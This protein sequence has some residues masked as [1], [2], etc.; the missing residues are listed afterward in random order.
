MVALISTAFCYSQGGNAIDNTGG[1]INNRGKIII[2][3]GQVKNLNDTIGGR[4]EFTDNG[5]GDTK[6]PNIVFN[7]LQLKGGNRKWTDTTNSNFKPLVTQDSIIIDKSTPFQLINANVNAHYH[8]ANNANIVGKKEFRANAT[9]NQDIVG[10][11]QFNILNIDN[12]NGVNIKDGSQRINSHLI[13]TNGSLNN[14]PLNN[15]IMSDS[16]LITRNIS[17]SI[18]NPPVFDNRVSV[19]YIGNGN[20]VS[21]YEIPLDST[22]LQNLYAENDTL[23]ISRNV[24]VNDSLHVTNVVSTFNP[25]NNDTTIILTHASREN[26]VY[27]QLYSEVIGNFRRT[28]LKF[29]REKNLFHNRYTYI[30][31]GR[32]DSSKNVAEVTYNIL[33]FTMPGSTRTWDNALVRRFMHISA[34]NDSGNAVTDNINM[35]MGFAWKKASNVDIDENRDLDINNVLL[36]H[37]KFTWNDIPKT[38]TPNTDGDWV[39]SY[40]QGINEL[41]YFAIGTPGNYL[42]LVLNIKVFLEGAY[43]SNGKMTNDLANKR[44]LPLDTLPNIYPYN[45]LKSRNVNIAKLSDTTLEKFVDYVVVEIKK[46]LNSTAATYQLAMLTKDGLLIDPNSLGLV[47]VNDSIDSN[48]YYV[49]IRHRNHLTI[50]SADK[51]PL[52]PRVNS[53]DFDFTKS[54]NILGG[55]ASLKR[56]GNDSFGNLLFGMIGGEVTANDQINLT[57]A[58]IDFRPDIISILN[59][60]SM[61]PGYDFNDTNLDGIVTTKD[62]NISWNNRDSKSV[63]K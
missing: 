18:L 19:K 3:S 58:N 59:H 54:A 9:I 60:F 62:Y 47:K 11:G 14:D 40:E 20:I 17:G 39:Y 12:I 34:K 56:I 32:K 2:K 51:V 55:T 21:G 63:L 4:V 52:Y 35:G 48:E 28:N 61:K 24:T 26:P 45:L 44:L 37:E 22:K 53:Y 1:R 57:S 38:N 23:Y 30:L 49:A 25:A 43:R 7:Q 42:P 46:D 29:D 6:I 15:I 10:N 16:T 36:K 50:V 33:P 27:K 31:F 5:S 13:L 41:G 8:I